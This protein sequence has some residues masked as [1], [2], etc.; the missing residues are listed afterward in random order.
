MSA[1]LVAEHLALHRIAV[2]P[3]AYAKVHLKGIALMLVG[4]N[5]GAVYQIMT[6]HAYRSG[7]PLSSFLQSGSLSLAVR[8]LV[9]ALSPVTLVLVGLLGTRLVLSAAALYGLYRS[10][11]LAPAIALVCGLAIVYFLSITGPL[12]VDPR[13]R[14]PIVPPFTILAAI[15]CVDVFDRA[16]EW[17]GRIRARSGRALTISSAMPCAWQES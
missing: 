11:R 4:H 2:D 5:F 10:L 3:L 9:A 6:G 13:F 12:G 15:G 1:S 14:V 7:S 17:R 8:D 16:R